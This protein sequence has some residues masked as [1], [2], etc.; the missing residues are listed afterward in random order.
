MQNISKEFRG[1]NIYFMV[2]IINDQ[3]GGGG[4]GKAFAYS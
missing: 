3:P 2:N 4:K 1:K